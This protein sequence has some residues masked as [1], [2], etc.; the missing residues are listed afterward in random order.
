LSALKT[1]TIKNDSAGA[2]ILNTG[3]V[4]ADNLN[5]RSGPSSKNNIVDVL[6]RTVEV[7]CYE[8]KENWWKIHP[9]KE[10]W[11]YSKYVTVSN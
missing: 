9:S 10:Q 3:S 1:T 5:V 2:K 11:V 7:N 6:H 8:V 4:N